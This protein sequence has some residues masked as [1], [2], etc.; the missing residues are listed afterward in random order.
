MKNDET[1]PT[2]LDILNPHKKQMQSEQ[3]SRPLVREKAVIPQQ[4]KEKNMIVLVRK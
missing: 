3:F 2:S 4:V 1:E